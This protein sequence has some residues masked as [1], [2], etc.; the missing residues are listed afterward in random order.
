VKRFRVPVAT[1]DLSGNEEAYVVDALRSSWIASTGPYVARFEAEFARLIGAASVVAVTN[2]TVALH[3]SLLAMG[4]VP[5]DEVVVPAFA[6]IAIANACRYVGARPVFADV[7]PETWSIGPGELEAAITP[8]TRAVVVVH[9]Y[10][11]PADMDRILE[12]CRARGLAVVEDAAEAFGALY[13]G[14]PVGSLGDVGTFSFYANKIITSGEGGAVTLRSKAHDT[15][16]R[17]LR[18]H[19]MDPDHRYEFPVT[20]Y[21]YRT[22]NLACAIL[23]AQLERTEAILAQRQACFG[24][25]REQLS[26]VPG[27]AFQPAADW[28]TPAPW[29]FNVTV[30]PREYGCSAAE[31]ATLLEQDGIE[32]RPLF[33]AIHRQPPFREEAARRGARLPVSERLSASGLSLPSFTRLEPGLLGYVADRIRHHR[34]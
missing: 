1:V 6:Y 12:L 15:R 28:A 13:R 4:I 18:D 14:R 31:L 25:Y 32:T 8:R 19:G 7:D 9:N 20:G 24:S 33:P 17:Q 16:I 30:E 26:S 29:M 3:L 10:G 22:T 23:C 34:G 5:G 11:H 27:I 21:N 2:G